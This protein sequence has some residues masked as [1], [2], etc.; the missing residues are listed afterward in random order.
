[1]ISINITLQVFSVVKDSSLLGCDNVC[2]A[3]PSVSDDCS[4]CIVW[5]SAG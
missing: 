3:V 4:A 1:L 2:W 5:V